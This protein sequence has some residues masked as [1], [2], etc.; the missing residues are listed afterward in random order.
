MRWIPILLLAALTARAQEKDMTADAE[1]VRQAG[2]LFGL[3]FTDKEIA[4]MV[5]DAVSN[6]R[7]YN[8]LRGAKNDNAVGQPESSSGSSWNCSV[9]PHS[10]AW[11]A[12]NRCTSWLAT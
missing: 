2:E 8:L 1:R 9:L 12:S 5:R 7:R 10:S 11:C 3:N 4:L 6:V